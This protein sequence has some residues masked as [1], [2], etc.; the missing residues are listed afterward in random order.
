MKE[1]EISKE[2][3]DMRLDRYIS[4]IIPDFSKSSIQ[5]LLRKKNIKVNGKKAE[6]N[7]R[8]RTG[9]IISFYLSDKY[10]LPIKKHVNT[11][12]DL[13]KLNII[14]ESEMMLIINKPA[15]VLSQPDGS[16][17]EDIVTMLGF[18]LSEKEHENISYGVINRLDRNTSGLIIAGKTRRALMLLSKLN[19]DNYITK[20]YMTLVKGTLDVKNKIFTHYAKK[21]TANNKMKVYDKQAEA[22]Q[23]IQTRFNTIASDNSYT[24]LTAMLLTGRFH[25][26]RSEL[27][28][29]GYPVIGDRKYNSGNDFSLEKRTHLKHQFLHAYE[30]SFKMN[31]SLN[32]LMPDKYDSSKGEIVFNAPLPT[33]LINVLKDTDI[34]LPKI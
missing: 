34:K 22:F 16:E 7:Y 21:D 10:F 2:F 25:Q 19:K 29:M 31:E 32:E 20:S 30:I 28:H 8:L 4:K 15:G 26:I 9:D 24:L 6:G 3:M 23:K 14:Y 27:N 33:E 18:Y 11:N 13:A 1:Y 5:K 12:I 17:N